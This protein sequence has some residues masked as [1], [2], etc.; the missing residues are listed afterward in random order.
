MLYLL[1]RSNILQYENAWNLVVVLFWIKAIT[2]MGK[3]AFVAHM[4]REMKSCGQSAAGFFCKFGQKT[5]SDGGSIS[6]DLA[7]HIAL[8]Y[9]E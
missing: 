3:S 8:S 2:G 6:M 5:R 7:Y 1:G 4:I 9:P